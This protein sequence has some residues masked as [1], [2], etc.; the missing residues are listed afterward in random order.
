MY[1]TPACFAPSPSFMNPLCLIG[2]R[3]TSIHGFLAPL[4]GLR[5]PWI[6]C[7]PV[8]AAPSMALEASSPDETEPL[9]EKSRYKAS[10]GAQEALTPM[11]GCG[12][13]AVGGVRERKL[14]HDQ[15]ARTS[16]A[17]FPAHPDAR[18]RHPPTIPRNRTRASVRYAPSPGYFRNRKNQLNSLTSFDPSIFYEAP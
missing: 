8:G 7:A 11:R 14:A 17:L 3:G 16:S 12:S 2:R 15:K 1:I 18:G 13:S 4:S 5:H 6:P 10:R 9:H